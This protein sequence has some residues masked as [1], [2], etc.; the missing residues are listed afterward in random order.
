MY[1]FRYIQILMK[2]KPKNT[3]KK[4]IIK[5]L[6]HILPDFHLDLLTEFF[7]VVVPKPVT[8]SDQLKNWWQGWDSPRSSTLSRW[9]RH[10]RVLMW[11]VAVL[12]LMLNWDLNG[13]PRLDDFEGF[14][15]PECFSYCSSTILFQRLKGGQAESGSRRGE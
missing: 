7:S 6:F 13:E 1:V 9:S 8:L 10:P 5:H 14:E 11:V 3:Y 15:A 4:Y 2:A 12:M